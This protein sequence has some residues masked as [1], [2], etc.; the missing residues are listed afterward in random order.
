MTDLV[1]L[2]ST[3]VLALAAAIPHLGRLPAPQGRGVARS[4]TCGSEVAVELCLEGGRI[5]EFAQ[6]VQAC[7][8]GQAAAG[9]LGG[10]VLGRS[11]DEIWAARADLAA[12]LKGGPVPAPPFAAFEALRAANEYPHRHASVLLAL[13]ATIAALRDAGALPPAPAS[14]A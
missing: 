13:D 14:G 7:A 8:L 5:S 1:K 9:V 12:M 2:Y 4:P 11:P 6:E 3:Q 10:A